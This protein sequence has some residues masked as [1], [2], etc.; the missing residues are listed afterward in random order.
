MKVKGPKGQMDVRLHPLTTLAE[1][2]GT[3]QVTIEDEEDREARAMWGLTRALVANAVRGVTDGWEK[4]LVVVGVGYRADLKGKN[5]ELQLGFSHPVVYEPLDGVSFAVDGG[6]PGI[7]NAQ[8]TI[9][10]S[11]IDKERVGRSAANLR[12]I[13]PPEP[14]KGKGIRYDG[15]LVRLKPGKS[16]AAV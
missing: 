9:T 12:K 3:L 8:A 5:L 7:D 4:K 2:D 13:R 11:G 6:P 15:E 16:A 1:T 14:Y 10:V